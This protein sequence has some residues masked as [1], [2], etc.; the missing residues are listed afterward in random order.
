[1]QVVGYCVHATHTLTHTIHTHPHTQLRTNPYPHPL[2]TYSDTHNRPHTHILSTHF[3]S[4]RTQTP[5][6]RPPHTHTGAE[7]ILIIPRHAP[8]TPYHAHDPERYMQVWVDREACTFTM[9]Q[10]CSKFNYTFDEAIARDGRSFVPYIMMFRYDRM[11]M[12]V[13][14]VCVEGLGLEKREKAWAMERTSILAKHGTE[15]KRHFFICWLAHKPLLL[16]W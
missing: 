6:H 3:T 12:A 2:Q 1:M 7:G 15:H 4:K 13:G 11:S 9:G 16:V 14:G 10:S 8:S 5:T